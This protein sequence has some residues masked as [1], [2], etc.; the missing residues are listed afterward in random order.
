MTYATDGNVNTILGSLAGRLPATLAPVSEFLALAHTTVLDVLTDVYPA[1]VPEFASEGLL[2]VTWAEAKLAA[3]E[4]L[5]AVRVNLPDLGDAPDR[6]RRE[7]MA[8]L[9]GGVVGYPA[10]S[11]SDPDNP[12]VTAGPRV[13]SFTQASAFPDPYEALRGRGISGL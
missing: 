12:T 9:S 7:A 3:A 10:G 5:G 11:G 13:S 6:L 2:A 4:I 1:G 8:T